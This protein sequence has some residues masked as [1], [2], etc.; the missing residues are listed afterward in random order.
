MKVYCSP[1]KPTAILDS[2][3]MFQAFI[4]SESTLA[5]RKTCNLIKTFN[6]LCLNKR[7]LNKFLVLTGSSSA[8]F[9]GILVKP[10][11]ALILCK[12]VG[13]ELNHDKRTG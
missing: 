6:D 5:E 10:N 7:S 2:P 12:L 13:T 3:D 11:I 8:V 1:H 4:F 9:A